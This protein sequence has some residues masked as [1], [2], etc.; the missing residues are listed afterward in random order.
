MYN[1]LVKK[2]K[3]VKNLY[4]INGL[5]SHHVVD[6]ILDEFSKWI[7]STIPSQALLQGT[8]RCEPPPKER[9]GTIGAGCEIME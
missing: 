3:S 1:T 2:L 5:F 6:C 4:I 9:V 8:P 7:A